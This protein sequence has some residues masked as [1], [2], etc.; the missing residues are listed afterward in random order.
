MPVLALL[1]LGVLVG[2][3]LWGIALRLRAGQPETRAQRDAFHESG[4]G[5]QGSGT[6]YDR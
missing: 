6:P 4:I 5:Q 1:G 2:F 3:A